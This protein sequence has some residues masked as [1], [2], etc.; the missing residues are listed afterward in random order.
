MRPLDSTELLNVWEYGLNQSTLQQ[1]LILITAASPELDSDAVARLSIGARDARLLQLREW[2]FGA[3]LLNTAQCPHCA[4][5]VE[6]EGRTADMRLQG[7]DD[8]SADSVAE[9]QLS[10]D[11][12]QLHF[13]LPT[14]MD[15]A[16]VMA[17][18][19]DS[20]RAATALIERCII[21][22]DRAGKGCDLTE[23]P[24]HAFEALS[25]QIEKLDPQADIR[26]ELTC[27][28]CSHQWEVL[29][30][31]ASFLW[32]EINTWAERTLRTVHRLATAYGW[33]EADIL[34][35]TPVRRQLYL[36]MV[37]R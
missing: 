15:I 35:L 28:E 22:V 16:T 3:T 34:S 19:E 36:G 10:V 30:D 9:F 26:T 25:Q 27:P 7:V 32:I 18:T 23:L 13:R 8:V 5:R 6:W 20:S 17:A 37:G 2:M 33:R 11:D 1:A 29:F 14:S 4:E 31:I 24:Q 21:S 12:Y